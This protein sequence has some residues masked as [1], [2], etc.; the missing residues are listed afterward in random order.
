VY[1]R[2]HVTDAELP[3]EK[4]AEEKPLRRTRKKRGE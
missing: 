3:E 2:Q 4:P 1:K